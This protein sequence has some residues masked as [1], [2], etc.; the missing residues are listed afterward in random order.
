VGTSAQKKDGD[1]KRDDEM[2][3]GRSDESHTLVLQPPGSGSQRSR[4]VAM[5]STGTNG[6]RIGRIHPPSEAV[7]VYQIGTR[8]SI[9][10]GPAAV[11]LQRVNAFSR[12]LVA[13]NGGICP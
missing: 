10:V 11:R 5:R 9:G 8:L 13:Q 4:P 6:G 1:Q 7:S 12:I 2:R 3:S